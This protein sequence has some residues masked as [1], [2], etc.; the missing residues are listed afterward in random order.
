MR[1]SAR[2]WR[3]RRDACCRDV[4]AHCQVLDVPQG[5]YQGPQR[6]NRGAVYSDGPKGAYMPTT[7]VGTYAPPARLLICW[8]LFHRGKCAPVSFLNLLR[9]H[10]T[11]RARSKT[12][13]KTAWTMIA[14]YR[15]YRGC[16]PYAIAVRLVGG[17]GNRRPC[18]PLPRNLTS[19]G[20]IVLASRV[21][22]ARQDSFGLRVGKVNNHMSGRFVTL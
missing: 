14:A 9:S 3:I 7:T 13:N 18:S 21:N 5:Y 22:V 19:R 17:A 11:T 6:A 15:V 1:E 2:G 4:C 10:T 20:S 12:P 8:C 16:G